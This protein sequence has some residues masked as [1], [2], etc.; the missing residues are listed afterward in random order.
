MKP[1]DL[2]TFLLRVD[3][4]LYGSIENAGKIVGYYV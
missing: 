2:Y 1:T 3:F 4:V